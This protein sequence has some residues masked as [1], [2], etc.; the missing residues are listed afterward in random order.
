[1]KKRSEYIVD[2]F[3]AGLKDMQVENNEGPPNLREEFEK[4][5][6]EM[7]LDKA[8]GEDDIS[9]EMLR[10]LGEFSID[11]ITKIANTIYF[12]GRVPEQT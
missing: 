10:V 9:I 4:G 1:M 8:I 3:E 11:K 5:M 7:K 12:S 2:L 6:L